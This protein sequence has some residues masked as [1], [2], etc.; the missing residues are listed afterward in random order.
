MD[1]ML[2]RI[3][4]AESP[5]GTWLEGLADGFSYLLLFGGMAIG[6]SRRWG[7]IT[8]WTGTL[9]LVGAVL[10]LITTSLQRKRATAPDRPNE[11]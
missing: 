1:G 9:L 4:F 11:Y 2:A 3:K 6:L 7:S 10:A 8:E 5:R